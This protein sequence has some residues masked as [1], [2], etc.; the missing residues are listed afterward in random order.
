MPATF[1][2]HIVRHG[3]VHNPTDVLYGRLPGFHLSANGQAQAEAAA[4]ALSTVRLD[5][6]YASPM[7]RAQETAGFIARAQVPPLAVRTDERLNECLTRWEG[8]AH[9]VL[10]AFNYEIYQDAQPP[11]ETVADMRRRA[12]AFLQEMRRKHPGGQIAAVTHGD[13]LVTLFM[14]AAGQGDTGIGRGQLEAWG[15]PERY[16]ATASILTLTYHSDADHEVP[17][18][19]YQ[20]PY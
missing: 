13:I 16:P 20:R 4:R 9:S 1:T 11:Y 2:A 19:R 10:A 12:V 3:E 17:G 14:M 6:L 8:T 7:E 18:W 15:L 5:A